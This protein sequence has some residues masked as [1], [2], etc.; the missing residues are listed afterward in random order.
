MTKRRKKRSRKPA[1]VLRSLLEDAIAEE[2]GRC[3]VPYEYESLR[4]SYVIPES[5]HTYTPDFVF[6]NGVVVE[7]KGKLCIET[8]RKMLLVKQQ[9][10]DV[11]LRMLF[12]QNN[13]LVRRGK[14]RYSDW[15]RQ[16]GFPCCF[17][18]PGK[19]VD[20]D[21]DWQTILVRWASE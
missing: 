9:N 5:D 19:T 20:Q 17:M 10:P 14:Y 13:L 18:R 21:D 6:P 15:A 4:L 12:D 1:P 2:L 11:D 3:G 7:C 8:R 16:K